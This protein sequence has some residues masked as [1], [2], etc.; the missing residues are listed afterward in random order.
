MYLLNEDDKKNME[1]L[2]FQIRDLA[3][4]MICLGKWGHIG[5][6]YSLSEIL[7]VLYGGFAKVNPEKPDDKN[8]DYIVL[9]KA[10]SSP[11]LYGALLATGFIEKESIYSYCS[12]NGLEGHLDQLNTPG[13]EMSGGSLGIGLSYC[14]GLALALKMQERYSQ[15]VYCIL[16]DGELSEGEI[17]EGA[18]SA[19]QYKLDN[20]VAIVD[21]NKVMAKGFIYEG[22]S[23]EPLVERFESFGWE[24]I[25]CD[26]H[27]INDIFNS[28]YK[29]KYISVIGKPICIIAHTVKGRGV[30]EC[31][32]NYKWHTHAPSVDKANAFL[33]ELAMKYKHKF[34]P[35]NQTPKLTLSYKEIVMEVIINGILFEKLKRSLW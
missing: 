16:G 10:H 32:F 5:G 31:E 34:V 23:Q 24:V 25:E 7:C 20:L 21:Y 4:R 1:N 13:I 3:T 22:M 12:V 26:G 6:S 17:W 14:V 28:L 35:I 19:A 30:E 27:N 2:A 15:R 29:S 11:A 33:E 8:R 9:S 18:M